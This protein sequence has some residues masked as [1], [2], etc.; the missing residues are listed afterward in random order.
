MIKASIKG[1]LNFPKLELAND[2]LH[3]ANRIFIPFIQEAIDAGRGVDGER[4]PPLEPSTIRM[5]KGPQKLIETGKLRVAF[6]TRKVGVNAVTIDL[7]PDRDRIGEYLQIEG[8][9]RRKKKFIFFGVSTEMERRAIDFINLQVR[10][11]IKRGGR[12]TKI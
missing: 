5:K 1:E 8:V 6:R 10:K 11:A 9:G 12:R 4:H 2:L 3:I 7:R